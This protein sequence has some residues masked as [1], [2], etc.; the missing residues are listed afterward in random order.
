MIKS[1]KNVP[2]LS[3]NSNTVRQ[4]LNFVEEMQLITSETE[5]SELKQMRRK[6]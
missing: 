1:R 2:P 6:L 4:Q 3:S 5:L